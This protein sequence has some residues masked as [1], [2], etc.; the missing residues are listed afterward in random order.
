MSSVRSKDAQTLARLPPPFAG[1]E[2]VA[3][4]GMSS[5]AAAGSHKLH[6]QEQDGIVREALA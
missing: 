1:S 3:W 5:R 6:V 4:T 2:V